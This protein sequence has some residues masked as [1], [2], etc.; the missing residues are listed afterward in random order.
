MGEEGINW[1]GLIGAGYDA[2][3]N[4][5]GPLAAIIIFALPFLMMWISQKDLTL[6]GIV[7]ALLGLFIIVR[8]PANWHVAAVTFIAISVVAVIYSLVKERV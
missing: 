5:L 7:G 3:E 2:Y 4:P 1:T 6:P 8:L